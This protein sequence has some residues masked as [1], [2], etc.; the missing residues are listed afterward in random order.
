GER[1]NSS[2]TGEQFRSVCMI[3]LDVENPASLTAIK[4][5]C[6]L[7]KA[8]LVA[9]CC[10]DGRLWLLSLA[11]LQDLVQGTTTRSCFTS[12]DLE[13]REICNNGSMIL[14]IAQTDKITLVEDVEKRCARTEHCVE[15]WCGQLEGKIAIVQVRPAD[16]FT[17]NQIVVDHYDDHFVKQSLHA[18]YIGSRVALED[19]NDVFTLV[20]SLTE[21]FIW[22][23]LHTG[24]F[25]LLR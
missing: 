16:L 8:N 21:P 1:S 2:S 5:I 14:C 22:S 9:I 25:R 12:T 7:C 11:K 13:D 20:A 19:R 10:N 18:I 23:V 6:W 15:I 4:S 3:Q 24:K 17:S